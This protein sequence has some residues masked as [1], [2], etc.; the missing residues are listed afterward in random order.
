MP[1][2]YK[3]TKRSAE[4]KKV[5]RTASQPSTKWFRWGESYTN[6]MMGVIVVIIA[7]LFVGS[8]AKLR[9]TQQVTSTSIVDQNQVQKA[10]NETKQ[11]QS[12][13][14]SPSQKEYV[15]QEGDSL[16]NIAE[17]TYGSGYNWVDIAKA[18]NVE[19]PDVLFAGTK[20]ALPQ[21]Q[22]QQPTLTTPTPVENAIK[23]TTYTVQEGD[24]LWNIAVRAYADG[25]RWTD[26]A[27]VNNLTQPDL[28]YKGTILKLPR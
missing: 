17:Q 26:I 13:L 25:Y 10:L 19:N 7:F 8:L 28:I 15:V 27:K 20:L 22:K 23:T 11:S 16:W 21:V 3:R 5:T 9:H 4:S 1:R 14:S 18:N 6:L 24:C 12:T 2:R